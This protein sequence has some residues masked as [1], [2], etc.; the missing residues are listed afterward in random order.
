MDK[1][2]AVIPARA[3]SKRIPGK[4]K[5]SFLGKPLIQ[6]TI[7]AAIKA[8]GVAQVVVTTDDDEILQ[9]SSLFPEVHFYRRPTHLADDHSSSVDVALDVMGRYADAGFGS[10]ILLQPTSPLRDAACLQE[11]IEVF[12]GRKLKQLV[13]VRRCLEIP[14]HIMRAQNGVLIPLLDKQTHVRS[15]DW[16]PLWVLNGAIYITDWNFY[17][18]QKTFLTEQT[19]PFEMPVQTSVDIDT[20]EDWDR[21][22][23]Q[24]KD[25]Y[26]NQKIR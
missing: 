16:G 18:A 2:L 14:S 10:L 6:W 11:A 24:A 9:M 1:M 26:A 20:E 19:A 3:G 21:A 4:N 17:L 22:E 15:Q 5:R 23:A 13:S 12:N 25:F 8:S 7:E